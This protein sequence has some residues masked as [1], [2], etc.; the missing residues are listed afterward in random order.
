MIIT[1]FVA[2]MPSGYDQHSELENHHAIKNAKPSISMGHG[3]TMANCNS[4]NQRV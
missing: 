1:C 4:H 2:N 3:L